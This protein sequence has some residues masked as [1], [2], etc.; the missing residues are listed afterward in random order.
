MTIENPIDD[1]EHRLDINEA[2]TAAD[3]DALL[4]EA[5]QRIR[6]AEANRAAAT[7]DQE[8][9]IAHIAAMRAT[10][11]IIRIKASRSKADWE[12]GQMTKDSAEE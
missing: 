1:I 3:A 11:D 7:T 12:L 10:E 4:A 5:E 2:S 8:R 6:D 9:L